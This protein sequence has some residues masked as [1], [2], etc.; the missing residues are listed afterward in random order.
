[1]KPKFFWEFRWRIDKYSAKNYLRF[2][3]TKEKFFF[4]QKFQFWTL[5]T[6]ICKSGQKVF[7]I[8]YIFLSSLFICSIYIFLFLLSLS[9]TSMLSLSLS[10]TLSLSFCF[11]LS[12]SHS[13][14]SAIQIYFLFFSFHFHFISFTLVCWF[15][16]SILHLCL[17]F[18]LFLFVLISL[19]RSF[20]KGCKFWKVP[21][22]L[23]SQGQA[24]QEQYCLILNKFVN[25]KLKFWNLPRCSINFV[26]NGRFLRPC[27]WLKCIF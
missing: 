4:C 10:V 18:S 19:Y 3:E 12:V 8:P 9:L 17:I 21:V 11:C 6:L 23:F 5:N 22:I 26:I 1:M 14:L 27:L 15:L 20:E 2:E 24:N 13:S 7:I 16:S 25:V